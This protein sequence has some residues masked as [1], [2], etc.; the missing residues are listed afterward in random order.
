[1]SKDIQCT[2]CFS[3]PVTRTHVRVYT[4]NRQVRVHTHTY[5]NNQV[6]LHKNIIRLGVGDTAQLIA[7]SYRHKD[8]SLICRTHYENS[9][10]VACTC[11]PGVEE[12]ET[13]VSLR[14]TGRQAWPT[15]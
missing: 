5:T 6:N 3:A 11:N 10:M 2:L 4:H 13:D 9:G 1:M 14:L 8:M 12:V 15:W 7:Q